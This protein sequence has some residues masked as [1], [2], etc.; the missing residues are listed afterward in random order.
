[1]TIVE[2]YKAGG[3]M[4]HFLLLVS[5]VGLA[6]I[7]VKYFTLT[8]AGMKSKKLLG[9][10]N[11]LLGQRKFKEARD[12][13]ESSKG[14]VAAIL[15]A[16]LRKIN[17]GSERV[18]SAIEHSGAM[19]LS[20][21]ERGLVALATIATIAPLM[22]FLGTVA[23]MIQAFGAI[24]AYGEVEATLVAGGIKV[25][26]ITT[27]TGLIIAIPISIAH[28]YFVT[29]VDRIILDMEET[30]ENMIDM[31]YQMEQSESARVS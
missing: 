19:E 21:L 24:E 23:G 16:G 20:F 26:L 10:V 4:M 27:A 13:C 22:G 17:Q 15:S 6:I 29:K 28:S 11:E 8:I 18:R 3:M 1:L 30:S 2:L 12:L 5:I 31:I 7:I 9:E 14:P 25:A